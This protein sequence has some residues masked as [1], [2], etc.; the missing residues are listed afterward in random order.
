VSVGSS[1]I[2]NA[3]LWEGTDNRGQIIYGK[4]KYLP[5]NFAVL[6]LL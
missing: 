2:T 4:C 1:I 5:L 6:E 3:P